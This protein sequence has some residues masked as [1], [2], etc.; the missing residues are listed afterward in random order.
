VR[1]INNQH[2]RRELTVLA[3]QPPL[4]SKMR[5]RKRGAGE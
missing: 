5:A 2:P 4:L 3:K 1:G